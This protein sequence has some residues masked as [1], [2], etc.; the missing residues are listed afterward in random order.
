MGV[1]SNNGPTSRQFMIF[2]E[3]T[4]HFRGRGREPLRELQKKDIVFKMVDSGLEY[5]TLG[6][7]PIR[8][9][10]NHA[11]ANMSKTESAHI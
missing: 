5:T 6:Y 9:S 8:T 3:S 11:D 7:N 2:S 1:L 10:I 4:L